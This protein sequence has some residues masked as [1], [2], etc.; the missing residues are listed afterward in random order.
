[1][2]ETSIEEVLLNEAGKALAAYGK[3]IEKS[4]KEADAA[5]KE[6]E[7][8]YNSL[9][10][11]EKKAISDAIKDAEKAYDTFEKETAKAIK[12]VNK[13]VSTQ[14]ELLGKVFDSALKEV[15]AAWT[16]EMA[17][18]EKAIRDAYDKNGVEKAY[19]T[20][21]KKA[22]K[23]FGLV[24]DSLA[25][26]Y[27]TAENAIDASYTALANG[28]KTA[29][30]NVG[31]Y[32]TAAEK[33][34]AK[35]EDQKSLIDILTN[36]K[37]AVSDVDGEVAKVYA[38]SEK[39]AANAFKGFADA[40]TKA[41]KTVVAAAKE[42]GLEESYKDL[43]MAVADTYAAAEKALAEANNNAGL[44]TADALK[45]LG[46]ATDIAFDNVKDQIVKSFFLEDGEKI[47]KGEK[48]FFAFL[49]QLM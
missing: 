16:K 38:D 18:A 9:S 33:A 1:M 27:N 19:K 45:T 44:V 43:V 30:E 48:R 36:F 21:E 40:L 15:E 13:V 7:K 11:E 10:E 26:E 2:S 37:K 6:I 32:Y 31:S 49:K 22:G 8:A 20:F 23:L 17:D 25:A 29:V 34:A 46:K 28:V 12:E 39:G 4:I 24:S 14:S 5:A 42:E 47:E 3:S 41:E 35:A